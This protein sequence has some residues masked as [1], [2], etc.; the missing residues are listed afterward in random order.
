M[1]ITLAGVA[2][3]FVIASVVWAFR[4]DGRV[5]LLEK[6]TSQK[7]DDLSLLINSKFENTQEHLESQDKRLTRIETSLD[8]IKGYR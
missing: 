3:P 2:A 8:R 1:F 6:L 5:N 4:V 7:I